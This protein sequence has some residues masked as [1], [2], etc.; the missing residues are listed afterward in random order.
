MQSKIGWLENGIFLLLTI[1]HT[2][3]DDLC[4]VNFFPIYSD[5]TFQYVHTVIG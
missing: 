5:N 3:V 1:T 2:H 4:N